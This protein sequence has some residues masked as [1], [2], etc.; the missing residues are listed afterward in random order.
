ML[1]GDNWRTARAVAGRLGVASVMADVQPADKA[2]RVR[3]L[4]L[5]ILQTD[6]CLC[7]RPPRRRLR[8]GRRAACGQG[9]AGAFDCLSRGKK[10]HVRLSL[11]EAA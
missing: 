3:F 7:V 6:A 1:T 11:C 4:L 5:F 8:H 9:R 10:P 2:A